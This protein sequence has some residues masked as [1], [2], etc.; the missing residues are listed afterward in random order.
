MSTTILTFGNS[1]PVTLLMA[2]GKPSPGMVI[3]PHLTSSEIPAARMVHP[4][5][6]AMAFSHMETGSSQ[7]MR[8]RFRSISMPNTK[9]TSN[10]NSC[11]GSNCR[12]SIPI[13]PTT[14]R[15]FMMK[16]YCPILS[17]G[18]IPSIPASW[19]T[20]GNTLITLA[21]NRLFTQAAIPK[22]IIY[23]AIKSSVCC[24]AKAMAFSF[25]VILFLDYF[26]NGSIVL[27]SS[28]FCMTPLVL[29]S[30]SPL[31]NSIRVG[32]D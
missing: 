11:T 2:T 12:R 31:R 21:P 19:N 14:S 25:F 7:E 3:L 5:N 23:R 13:C 29:Q 10:W 20:Y 27:S 28:A 30:T 17:D 22:V 24:Q 18:T 6:W 16:V 15:A 4:A 26:R 8:Y 1:T 9:P 32:T